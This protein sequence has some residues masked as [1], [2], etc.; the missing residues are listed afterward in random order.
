MSCWTSLLVDFRFS[1]WKKTIWR[2]F[3]RL[4][5]EESG[6]WRKTKICTRFSVLFLRRNGS[7]FRTEVKIKGSD[8]FFHFIL[9]LTRRIF[10]FSIRVIEEKSTTYKKLFQFSRFHK[11]YITSY[12]PIT[13]GH[14]LNLWN[15]KEIYD[16][17]S[18]LGTSTRHWTWQRPIPG[19]QSFKFSHLQT[20]LYEDCFD[21]KRVQTIPR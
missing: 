19:I 5:A 2:I 21:A 7:K 1:R 13:S 4:W 20:L 3:F 15:R 8:W 12:F 14:T 18:C 6:R 10:I 11:W 17:F 16:I 9:I